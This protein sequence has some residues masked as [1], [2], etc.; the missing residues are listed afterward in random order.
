M[1]PPDPEERNATSLP[2]LTEMATRRGVKSSNETTMTAQIDGGRL[3]AHK[4]DGTARSSLE[5]GRG[6]DDDDGGGGDGHDDDDP[7]PHP[8]SSSV[9]IEQRYRDERERAKLRHWRES[10]YAAGAVEPTWEDELESS[11]R[12]GHC[13]C[14]ATKEAAGQIFR[15]EIDPG[16]GCTYMSA[17]VCSRLGAGRIGNM[18]ILKERYVMVEAD[19]EQEEG[20]GREQEDGFVDEEEGGTS[21]HQRGS[22]NGGGKS[23]GDGKADVAAKKKRLVRKREI[24]YVV[25][26]FW[27][28]LVFITY[29]LI[30]GVS[31]LTLHSGLPG[32]PFVVQLGWA[33]LTGGL[34]YSLF[35]TGF[36]D[37]GILARHREPPPVEDDLDDEAA[38]GGGRRRNPFRW[39]DRGGPWA[40]SDQAQSYRPRNS[41]YC[42]DCKVVVEEFDHTCPWTGTAIGKKN[43]GS[44]Q[45]F[46]G[47]VFACLIMDIFLLTSGAIN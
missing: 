38:R 36:R 22:A 1:D 25:G 21:L 16:C 11:R 39:R 46:V 33:L 8:S 12:R 37:P 23:R 34:I 24:Q 6:D 29:P 45:M 31:A 7:V 14:C 3:A 44:F 32:K 42:P 10:E 17:L 28:M 27:P 30:F 5:I 15:E 20:E 4:G 35:K 9:D 2:M 41:M 40:W 19:D 47:L 43:M 26:P 13:C 18:A